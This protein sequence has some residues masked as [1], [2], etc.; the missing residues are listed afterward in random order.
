M[1]TITMLAL[2]VIILTVIALP[3]PIAL[4]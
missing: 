2:P 1:Q 4:A 3:L